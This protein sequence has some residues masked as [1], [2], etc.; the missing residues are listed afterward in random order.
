MLTE[1]QFNKGKRPFPPL[2]RKT[3]NGRFFFNPHPPSPKRPFRR[4]KIF[5]HFEGPVF[6]VENI[7]LA[8]CQYVTAA[9]F[10]PRPSQLF[11]NNGL[12]RQEHQKRK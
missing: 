1:L 4:G 5:Q 6:E 12:S 8:L 10:P 11:F 7:G 2:S 9:G 3:A